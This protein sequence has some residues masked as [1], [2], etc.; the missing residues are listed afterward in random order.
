[1][2]EIFMKLLKIVLSEANLSK[3]I[4]LFKEISANNIFLRF[5]DF[6]KTEMNSNFLGKKVIA[7][8]NENRLSKQE[9]EFDLR[10]RG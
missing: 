8:F 10:F 1:M 7:W 2:K 9:R 6:V 5:V 3:E 4:K